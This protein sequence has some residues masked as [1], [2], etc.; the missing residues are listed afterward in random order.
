MRDWN[1]SSLNMNN[2]DDMKME[3][4]E[5]KGRLLELRF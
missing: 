2:V 3:V 1:F 4:V 5:R